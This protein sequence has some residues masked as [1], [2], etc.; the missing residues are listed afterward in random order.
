MGGDENAVL[1]ISRDKTER[2]TRAAKDSVARDLAHRIA[3]DLTAS[4]S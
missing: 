3:Q 1:L 2:W 4:L